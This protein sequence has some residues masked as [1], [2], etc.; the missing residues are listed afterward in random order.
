MEDQN[1][2][3]PKSKK[4]KFIIW[5][6]ILLFGVITIV[7]LSLFGWYKLTQYLN[8]KKVQQLAE[9]LQK[10]QEEQY[11]KVMSDTYGGKTPQETLKMYI[12]AVEKGD[13][14]LASKYFI[15]G[16]REKEKQSLLNSKREDIENILNL[17][18]Q[19]LKSDGSFS[20]DKN[21]FTI[22]KPILVDFVRYP[23]GIWKIIEI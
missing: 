14:E 5:F 11:Q 4:I 21:G 7:N 17:L 13:Y 19:S 8:T 22:R 9:E 10:Q 3:Q 12:D 2:E 6:V 20:A 23:N 1:L 15:E 18:K 16:K